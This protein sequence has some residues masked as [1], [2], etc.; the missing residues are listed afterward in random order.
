MTEKQENRGGTR[1]GAGRKKG[2]NKRKRQISL[3]LTDQQ[4]EALEMEAEAENSRLG[5]FMNKRAEAY[6]NELIDK[7]E[8]EN[9]NEL[10]KN[11]E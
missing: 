7:L 6:A 10:N 2:I 9:H 5:T 11:S 8:L 4:W 3:F 1:I